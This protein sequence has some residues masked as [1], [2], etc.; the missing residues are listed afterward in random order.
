VLIRTGATAQPVS[1]V[2][3][4]FLTPEQNAAAIGLSSFAVGGA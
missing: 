4:H 1:E 2:D 3:A